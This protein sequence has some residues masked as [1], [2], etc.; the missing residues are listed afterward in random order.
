MRT[1]RTIRTCIIALIYS[2]ASI[3][4]SLNQ[5]IL[6][7]S[8]L[9]VLAGLYIQSTAHRSELIDNRML[10]NEQYC[11]SM[12]NLQGI[13]DEWK[14]HHGNGGTEINMLHVSIFS[15]IHSEY[16]TYYNSFTASHCSCAPGL[17]VKRIQCQPMYASLEIQETV[18]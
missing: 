7:V 15:L 6:F 9:I 3:S 5:N 2:C 4:G 1:K 13:C 18:G 11:Y 8:E 16:K 17:T 10:L 14:L 12:H